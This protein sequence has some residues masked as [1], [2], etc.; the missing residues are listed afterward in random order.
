M[1]KTLVAAAVAASFAAPAVSFADV[2]ISGNVIQEFVTDSDDTGTSEDGLVSAAAV[3][4]VFSVS[5]DLGNGM[6]AF[7]K[8]HTLRDNGGSGNADQVVGIKGDFGTIVA[9]RMEDFSE[10]KV[11]AMAAVDSSDKLSIEP[12]GYHQTGRAEGGLAYV[13]P[14]FNGLT[15]GIA[16]YALPNGSTGTSSVAIDGVG[17]VTATYV[18]GVQASTETKS[19]SITNDGT[20]ITYSASTKDADAKFDA[21]DVMVEYANGPLLV[22]VAR[23]TVDGGVYSATAGTPDKETDSIAVS[24]KLDNITLVGYAFDVENGKGVTTNDVSGHFLG[25]KMGMGANTFSVSY[26]EED[27]YN[28]STGAKETGTDEAWMV[29][30]DHA[31]SKRTSL[32]AAYKSSDDGNS[33]SDKDELAVGIKHV[34]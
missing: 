19:V 34:F 16:G 30:V 10:G 1:K 4:L 5:E 12:N 6:S 25:A 28:T 2:A 20:S 14:S 3:D 27:D 29:S 17:G 26:M 31:L 15:F 7:A 21:T 11:A 33:T 18:S 23:E 22:R 24:Y 9:G 13:S 8:I 32:T